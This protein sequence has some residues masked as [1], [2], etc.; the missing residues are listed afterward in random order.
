[1]DTEPA[2]PTAARPD[3]ADR[4]AAVVVATTFPARAGDGTPEFVLTL[5]ASLRAF[6]V[7]V[8]V[9]RVP[10]AARDEV[11]DGV[12]VHRVAYFPARWEGLAADAIMPTLRAQ[13]WRVVEAPFLVGALVLATLR[14]V[15]RRRAV[16]VNPHWI[17][18]A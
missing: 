15:R 6:D 9:P 8:V 1:M 10:G 17:V 13:P 12:R 7:T 3:P 2:A 18:P 16:V 5:A 4:P 14:Q 11:I